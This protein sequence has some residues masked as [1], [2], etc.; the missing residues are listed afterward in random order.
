[1]KRSNK[2][3]GFTIIELLISIAVFGVVIPGLVAL[4]NGINDLNDRARDL[5]VINGLV[6]NKVESLRSISFVGINN[7]TV[8]FTSELPATIGG[9]KSANYTVSSASTSLKQIDINISYQDNGTTKNINYRTYL[10]EL[11]VGQY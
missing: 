11:G 5:S 2:Q 9:P 10:G 1:M 7:G 8:D 3:S 6:E 4:I